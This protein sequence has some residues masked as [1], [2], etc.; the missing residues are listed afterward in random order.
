MAARRPQARRPD[1]PP[2]FTRTREAAQKVNRSF[3]PTNKG[4]APQTGW[5]AGCRSPR[6]ICPRRAEQ[7]LGRSSLPGEGRPCF[8]GQP[9]PR[10]RAR[11]RAA[12]VDISSESGSMPTPPRSRRSASKQ[13][14]TVASLETVASVCVRHASTSFSN[15]PAPRSRMSTVGWLPSRSNAL[16]CSYAFGDRVRIS[17]PVARP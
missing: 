10:A 16:V 6:P 8:A 12:S 15:W 11:L 14:P 1:Q 5:V 13:T 3:L 9:L 4:G 7:W 17:T 2:A